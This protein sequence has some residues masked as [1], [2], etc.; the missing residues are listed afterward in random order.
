MLPNLFSKQRI[1]EKLPKSMQE[2][3][4]K[5]KKSKGKE[6]CLRRAYDIVTKRYNGCTWK[7]YPLL[8]R[9]VR[10]SLERLWE[11][12]GFLHCHHHNFLLRVLLV[13]SGFFKEDDVKLKWTLKWYISP[14]QYL[15]VRLGKDKFV[16]VDA[17]AHV[18]GVGLGDYSCGFR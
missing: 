13:R 10:P 5:L 16:N 11:R 18:Y 15:R 8:Y 3:V 12:N 7:T 9:I 14:H 2:A 6:D 17:W 1:P 4:D